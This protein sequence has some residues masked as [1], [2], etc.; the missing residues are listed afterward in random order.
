VAGALNGLRVLD[1]SRVLA[2]PFCCMMLADHGPFETEV[3][4]LGR[5]VVSL[6]GAA[7]GRCLS[8]VEDAVVARC[9]Q[10]ANA[11]GRRLNCGS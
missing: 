4:P 11:A 1:M 9:R 10:V 6:S 8:P 5:G 2:G 7:S 3:H